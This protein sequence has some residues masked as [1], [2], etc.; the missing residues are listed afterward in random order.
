MATTHFLKY[1]WVFKNE[2][3]VAEVL[4]ND[5]IPVKSFNLG[6][7]NQLITCLQAENRR[8]CFSRTN[9]RKTT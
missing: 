1:Y 3:A 8:L 5:F 6:A 4:T 7:D 2:T 9:Y